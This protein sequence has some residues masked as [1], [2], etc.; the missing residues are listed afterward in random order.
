[1]FMVNIYY[2]KDYEHMNLS[3]LLE[4]S[5][6][7]K[8]KLSEDDI[9]FI[10]KLT[11]DQSNSWHWNKLRVGRVTGSTFKKACV[12]NLSK[13]AISTIK[14]ICWPENCRF[15]SPAM[16]YG[17]QWENVAKEDFDKEMAVAHANYTS[18]K[19][20]LIVSKT[21]NFLAVSP[22]GATKCSCCGPSVLE[23][24]CPYVLR[25]DNSTI[26][27]LLKMS[28][29]Y[30]QLQNNK[31]SLNRKHDYFFQLQMQMAICECRFGYFYVWSRHLSIPII[32]VE[33]DKKFWDDN[34]VK[35]FRF[36]KSVIIPEIMN[37]N[38][39]KISQEK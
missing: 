6:T 39:T 11:V 4:V 21:C 36:V 26:D 18:R 33:F 10:E 5:K 38:F 29:P 24:K 31:Y 9:D 20:G 28:N 27:N 12:T 19:T 1:M 23:I 35:A 13:P 7:I 34:S 37:S 25:K 30:I 22:D 8:L 2:K 16:R 17:R 14:L 3:E 15:D 32:K